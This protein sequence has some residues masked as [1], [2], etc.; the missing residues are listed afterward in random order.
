MSSKTV[1]ITFS[2]HYATQLLVV[3]RVA[4]FS[5]AYLQKSNESKDLGDTQLAVSLLQSLEGTGQKILDEAQQT[6]G[7]AR[8]Q[9]YQQ[10]YN[11]SHLCMQN[12][13]VSVKASDAVMAARA[14][15]TGEVTQCAHADWERL[16]TNFTGS[17]SRQSAMMSL[18]GANKRKPRTPEGTTY[19]GRNTQCS[20][21]ARL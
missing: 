19:H 14:L 9:K 20:F 21:G 6:T 11:T 5:M 2:S 13:D 4:Y 1:P 12:P 15:A 8:L 10:L 7:K 18:H 16:T 3:R 17:K